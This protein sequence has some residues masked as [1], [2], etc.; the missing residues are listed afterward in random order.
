[1]SETPEGRQVGGSRGRRVI[2][3]T[4]EGGPYDGAELGMAGGRPSYL[5]LM[6]PPPGTRWAGPLIVGADFDDHWPGQQRYEL[7][8]YSDTTATYV[9]AP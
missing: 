5:M 6:D 7:R 1:M 8:A 9:Y 2:H 4:F 3:A